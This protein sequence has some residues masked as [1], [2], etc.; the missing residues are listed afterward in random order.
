MAARRSSRKYH[1]G[2]PAS[3]CPAALTPSVDIVLG[4]MVPQFIYHVVHPLTISWQTVVAGLRA[5]QVPFEA[6]EA[7]H[8]LPKVDAL[9]PEDPSRQMLPLWSTAVSSL[10]LLT[11][12]SLIQQYGKTPG[13]ELTPRPTVSTI[14]AQAASET[15]QLITPLTE[16]DVAHM[17]VAWRRT[18]FLR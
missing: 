17:V 2:G 3:S 9:E 10:H 8:W 11:D 15:L 7:S 18:G 14:N 1:V 16:A 6:V 5:A 13:T 12:V 4:D